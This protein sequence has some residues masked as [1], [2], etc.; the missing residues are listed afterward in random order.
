MLS[1]VA[2]WIRGDK[3]DYDAWGKLVGDARWTYAGMLPYFR[4][5]EMHH[6]PYGDPEE[7]GFEGGMITCSVTSSGRDYP[8]RDMVK[9]AWEAVGLQQIPDSNSGSPQGFADLNENRKNG[10]RQL[11][12]DAYS[13]DGVKI[14]TE[15]LVKRV[16]VEE[17]DG[18]KIATGVELASGEVLRANK[19]IVISAGAYRTPQVLMLSGI[20]SATE[21]KKHGIAQLVDLPEV[22]KNLHDHFGIPQLYDHSSYQ[23]QKYTDNPGGSYAIQKKVTL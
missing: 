7:H 9:A 5:T 20:G 6:T 3:N 23:S 8:L 2:G 17:I 11:A 1:K 18:R 15:T 19:E 12:C 13:L 22:G 14:M 4:K 21:L 16:I 10:K